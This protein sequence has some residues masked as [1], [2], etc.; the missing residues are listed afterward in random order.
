MTNKAKRIKNKL[1]ENSK[2]LM[3]ITEEN[4]ALLSIFNIYADIAVLLKEWGLILEETDFWT[5]VHL[6][7]N[8][9]LKDL[10]TKFLI[11]A[12]YFAQTFDYQGLNALNKTQ[13]TVLNT[14]V[15]ELYGIV[16]KEAF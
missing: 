16:K 7:D 9:E 3:S 14:K 8:F 13:L 15:K 11:L 2:L 10:K 6:S 4:S 1:I 5:K 12:K